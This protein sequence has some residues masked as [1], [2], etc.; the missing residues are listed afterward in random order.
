MIGD[1][2]IDFK[3]E[4]NGLTGVVSSGVWPGDCPITDVKID[5]A[6][7]SFTGTGR[8]RSSTGI[9]ILRS[10]GEIHDDG[11]NLTMRHQIF[12]A[13]DGVVLPMDAQKK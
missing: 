13:D 12:G 8:I 4:G 10:K 7:I 3:V 11:L 9:P 6:R 1:M 5:H 2:M